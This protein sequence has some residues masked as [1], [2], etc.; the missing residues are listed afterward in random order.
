SVDDH[1]STIGCLFMLGSNAISWCSKKQPSIALS[2]SEDEYMVVSLVVCQAIRL[3]R[4]L[5]DMK[6]HQ[7]KATTI[8]YDN[9]STISM[10]KNP[11]HHNRTRHID[12]RHHYIREL[13]N[14]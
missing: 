6:Q 4:I 2:S 8:F 3:R 14:E 5:G 13:V 9:Q 7:K 11:F 10:T 1:K 12:T